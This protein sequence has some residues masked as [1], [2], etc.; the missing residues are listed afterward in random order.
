MGISTEVAV[1]IIL[2]VKLTVL[3]ETL[4]EGADDHDPRAQHDGPSTTKAVG[5]PGSDGH[6]E[7]GSELV[8]RVD[9]AEQARLDGEFF[10][11]LIPSSV[12]EV[13]PRIVSN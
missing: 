11:L 8:A 5:E 7:D 2:E 1:Q 3:S 9:E 4:Q 6:G 12:T 13:C 10:L